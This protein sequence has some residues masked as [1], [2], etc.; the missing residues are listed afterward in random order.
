MSQEIKYSRRT[1]V[2]GLSM[3]ILGTVSSLATVWGLAAMPLYANFDV[4]DFP[5]A[6]R[7]T[8]LGGYGLLGTL[9]LA[10]ATGISAESDSRKQL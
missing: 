2:L 1:D 7:A 9:V 5:L 3:L 6:Q 8:E 10:M 4:A